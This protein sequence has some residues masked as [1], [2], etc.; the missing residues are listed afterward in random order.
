MQRISAMLGT[1][2]RSDGTTQVTFAGWPLYTFRRGQKGGRR[3]R[4]RRKA[5]GA[6]WYPL[7]SNGKKAGH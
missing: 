4:D 5:F 3:E 7:H 2:K 1:I 6:S